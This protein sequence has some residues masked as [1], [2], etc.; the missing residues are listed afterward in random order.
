MPLYAENCVLKEI[1]AKKNNIGICSDVY[2]LISGMMN[3]KK[4]TIYSQLESC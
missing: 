1:N 3:V 2:E 4:F